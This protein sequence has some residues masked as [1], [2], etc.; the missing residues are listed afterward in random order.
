FGVIA[1]DSAPHTIVD[2]A[3]VNDAPATRSKILRIASEGGGIFIYEA[4]AGSAQM[5]VNAKA[6]TRHIILLADAADS[7]EPG[8]YQELIAKCQEAGITISVVGLGK[9]TDVD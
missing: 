7:E 9:E 4:L 3:P 5:L 2:L 8:K 1:V 6:G